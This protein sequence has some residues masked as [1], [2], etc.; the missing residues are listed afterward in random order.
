[1]KT[2]VGIDVAKD[3]LAVAY[4][5][6]DNVW[7]TGSFV[8]SP[9]GI[10]RLMAF[11]PPSAHC[12][13]EATGS[14]SVLVTY[15]LCQAQVMISVINP[16]Q[17]HHFA[18][19]RL[20]VTKTDESDAVLLARYGNMTQPPIYQMDND[21][22][23]RLRQKRT[24]LRQYKKQHR[25][26]R[27]LKHSFSCLPV[28][29]E[30]VQT[31]LA[32][33]ISQLEAAIKALF[34]EIEQL[35]KDNFGQQLQRLTS[36]VGISTSIATALIEVTGGFEQFHSAKALAKFIG[37]APVIYQSGKL[38]AVKGI[39][40]TGDAQLR[41][42]LYV[43][44]WSAIQHNKACRDLYHRLKGAGKAS[45]VALIAVV[46]KLLRQAFAVVKFDQDFDP[47]YFP[48]LRICS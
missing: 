42:M 18:K 5:E 3:S 16:K 22:L 11:L 14:Y 13:V 46:N 40:K 31:S 32:T 24:L 45:K 47:N 44:S 37:V 7:K 2:Y 43:A 35:T 39:C 12:V 15:M 19:M 48:V 23:L 21:A 9:E 33:I 27:N 17:S 30:S 25:A 6:S 8:N 10:K 41:S 28:K 36:I 4:A 20:S 1:M 38:N 29:D 34:D 26:M